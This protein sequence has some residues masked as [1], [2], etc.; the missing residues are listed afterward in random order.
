M[1]VSDQQMVTPNPTIGF[2]LVANIVS[3]LSYSDLINFPANNHVAETV[4]PWHSHTKC[5]K[6]QQLSNPRHLMTT[7][8]PSVLPGQSYSEVLGIGFKAKISQVVSR[9]ALNSLYNAC[10]NIFFPIG[11]PSMHH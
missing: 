10:P 11:I 1:R 5:S 7:V 2:P 3:I 8:M 6:M 9:L 4:H